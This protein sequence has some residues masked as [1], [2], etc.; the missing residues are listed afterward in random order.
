LVPQ[1]GSP[2]LQAGDPSNAPTTDERGLPRIVNDDANLDSDGPKIDIGAVEFQPIDVGITASGSPSSAGPGGTITYTITV[3]TGTGDN[4]AVNNLILTDAV[5]SQTTFQSF[6]APGGWAVTAPPVGGTGTV[7]ATVLSLAP[8]STATFTLK[9]KVNKSVTASSTTDT[10]TIT[11]TSPDPT[12][13]DNSATVKTTI[14][15]GWLAVG[16]DTGGQPEVKV[17]DPQ[18]DAAAQVWGDQGSFGVLSLPA[19]RSA[20]DG[21]EAPC[22]TGPAT[23]RSSDAD[24]LPSGAP[25]PSSATLAV[26]DVAVRDQLLG[27]AEGWSELAVPDGR[28]A[29]PTKRWRG[30]GVLRVA[31]P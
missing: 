14:L 18:H 12:T 2:A 8:S 27:S 20:A 16:A 17:F 11:T 30:S 19:T 29:G 15:V 7:K 1:V 28:P 3:K 9:V 25:M 26:A 21:A 23:P 4:P 5:P 10:A 24:G 13:T 6:T 22:V 31:V